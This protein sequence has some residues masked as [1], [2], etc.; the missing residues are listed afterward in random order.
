MSTAVKT[1]RMTGRRTIVIR[2]RQ[3]DKQ[4]KG[5][6]TENRVCKSCANGDPYRWK[7]GERDTKT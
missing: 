2:S 3:S 7:M 6:Q 1:G 4:K 5:R